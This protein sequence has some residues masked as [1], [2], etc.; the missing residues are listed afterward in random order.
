MQRP[1]IGRKF[2]GNIG[3]RWPREKTD[4]VPQSLW[5]LENTRDI[6]ALLATLAV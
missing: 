6:G 1:D 4:A 5:A 3:Q 2:R